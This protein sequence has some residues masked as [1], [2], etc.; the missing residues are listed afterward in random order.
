MENGNVRKLL[1]YCFMTLNDIRQGKKWK[2]TVIEAESSPEGKKYSIG[3]FYFLRCKFE[4]KYVI[5]SL[6]FLIEFN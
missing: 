5:N 6:K 4:E 1:G 2:W 3:T